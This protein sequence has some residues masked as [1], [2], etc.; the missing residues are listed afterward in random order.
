MTRLAM[1]FALASAFVLAADIS[2]NWKGTAEGPN[3]TFERTFV[4]KVDGTTLTGETVS[5][6]LGKSVINEG[7]VE[8]DA[9]SFTINA[10]FQDNDVKFTYKGKVAA[11]GK[12]IK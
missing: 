7:K 5:S 6:F 3:G 1:L 12:E 10:K 9:I 8:G 2:G 4:F 11:D